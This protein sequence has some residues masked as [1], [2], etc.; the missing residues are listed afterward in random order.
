MRVRVLKRGVLWL[1]QAVLITCL[2][3][4]LLHW[5]YWDRL[6]D[7][8]P[9]RI[10]TFHHLRMLFLAETLITGALAGGIALIFA[11]R[12]ERWPIAYAPGVMLCTCVALWAYVF[13]ALYG[14][15][16]F[17]VNTIFMG[18]INY[19]FYCLIVVTWVGVVNGLLSLFAGALNA[20][21]A[22]FREAFDAEPRP[23]RRRLVDAPVK[24]VAAAEEAA[25]AEGARAVKRDKAKK[26]KPTRRRG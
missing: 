1:I 5:N 6:S 19:K 12:V 26:A 3:W 24:V 13:V 2:A 15:D 18:G 4:Y 21:P 9:W 23:R 17:E 10:P 20:P 25:F 7:L 8:V 22:V 11:A 14:D 16:G